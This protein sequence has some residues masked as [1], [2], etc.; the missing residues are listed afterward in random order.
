MDKRLILGY[1]NYILTEITAPD[2][3]KIA[4]PIEFVVTKDGKV[5]NQMIKW[6]MKLS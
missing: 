6:S 2:G 3:Y 5:K 1:G 4:N